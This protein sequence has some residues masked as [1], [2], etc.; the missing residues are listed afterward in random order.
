MMAFE[1]MEDSPYHCENDDEL[2]K[3]APGLNHPC[4]ETCSGWQ[5][6]FEMGA[7]SN[8]SPKDR[9]ALIDAITAAFE[10]DEMP[11][12][13]NSID[14]FEKHMTKFF[15]ARSE[16][17]KDAEEAAR[18]TGDIAYE[19]WLASAH[20]QAESYAIE[21]LG[22]D[23]PDVIRSEVEAFMAGWQAKETREN[24]EIQRLKRIIAKELTENDEL[25]SEFV[26]VYTLKERIK[27]LEQ[28][29]KFT[30]KNVSVPAYDNK[31]YS[32]NIFNAQVAFVMLEKA[33]NDLELMDRSTKESD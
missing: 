21:K 11:Y 10:D 2:R 25:G 17:P 1:G 8:A 19:K 15:T 31:N 28:A 18:D 27:L 23:I 29:I 12:D 6:G 16:T 26:Y 9:Q 14:H 7:R 22:T 33:L 30:L 5:Q 32:G 24:D 3:T 20:K 13:G 4:K